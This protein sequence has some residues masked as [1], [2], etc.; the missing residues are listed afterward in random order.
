MDPLLGNGMQL[1]GF[2]CVRITQNMVIPAIDSL[3]LILGRLKI[4]YG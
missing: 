2:L 4:G 3:P 1:S